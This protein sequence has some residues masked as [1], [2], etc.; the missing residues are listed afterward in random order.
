MRIPFHVLGKRFQHYLGPAAKWLDAVVERT[1]WGIRGKL[2]SIFIVIKV[3][4][5]VL[6]AWFAWTQSDQLGKLLALDATQLSKT[7][8]QS[9]GDVGQLAT[10]DSM[11]ALNVRMREELERM[12]TDAALRIAGF[13]HERDNDIRHAASLE[14]DEKLYRAFLANHNG[15][16]TTQGRWELAPDGKTWQPAGKKSGAAEMVTSSI[17]ENAREF[18]YRAP[19]SPASRQSRPLFLEMTFVDLEGR[20]KVKISNSPRLPSELSDISRRENTYTKAET[21]F[22]DLKRLKPGDIY[23]SEVI[24]PYVGS[25]IIGHY[26]PEAA[27]KAGIPFEPEKAAYAGKE[28]PVGR[29]FQG[30]VR[31]AA[32]VVKDGRITGYVTLALD[33]DHLMEFTSTLIP[34]SERYTDIPDAAAGNYAFIWDHRG[35]NIA[36]PRHHFI[37]GYRPDTGKPEVPWLETSIEEAWRK[38]G[39]P[40]SEFIADVPTF[41]QQS[42]KKKLSPTLK[43]E[44]R[45][46]LD[47]RYLNAAPQCTGWFDLTRLGG[48][49]SFLISWSGLWKITTAAAIPYHT[50]QYAK[51]PR[52]FGIVTIGANIDEF[53]QPANETKQRIDQMVAKT[54]QELA[55]QEAATQATIR[56][57]LASTAWS[58]SLSTILMSIL[59]IVIAV[60]MASYLT[61]RIKSL[62][63]GISRFRQGEHSFRF[64][65]SNKDEMGALAT[66]FDAMADTIGNTL[67]QLREEIRQHQATADE[68][69]AMQLHLEQL[70]EQRTAELSTANMRLQ[71]EIVER[72][73]AEERARHLALHDPLT[74]LANRRQ[75]QDRLQLSMA[76][77]NRSHKG[78][79]LLYLDLDRFKQVNDSFGHETGD[80]LLKHVANQLRACVRETD[81]VARLGGDEFVALL[82][83]V[84]TPG[85]C[86]R[87]ANTILASLT[88]PVALLGHKL[89]PGTSIG[90]TFF[91]DDHD[92]PEQLLRQADMAMYQAKQSGGNAYRFFAED[93]HER[94]HQR[95]QME[96]DLRAALIAK[97]LVL[98]YQTRHE[99]D[100]PKPIGIEALI[101]W[102]HPQQ[103]LLLPET[104][105]SLA[106]SADQ[107][108]TIDAWALEEACRQAGVWNE[109]GLD[110]GRIAINATFANIADPDFPQRCLETL[111]RHKLSPNQVDIEITESSLIERIGNI[112][113]NLATLRDHGVRITLDDFGVQ[114]SSLH[115]LVDYPIDI[116]KIN[117]YFISRIDEDKSRA[118]IEAT[119]LLA[120]SLGVEV[121]AEGIET[122]AQEE[123]LRQH[124]CRI[125]QGMLY[126][127]PVPA[128]EITNRL[129]KLAGR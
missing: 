65:S 96:N 84:E 128:A 29:R 17:E 72:R 112:A 82:T 38:S 10:A 30:L 26:T 126:A 2:I 87:V 68:L 99:L 46:G 34:N 79:A 124:G 74:G 4:P 71:E 80:A 42:L 5:L 33:H 25:R 88:K 61:N 106:E 93:M 21:Y 13:L 115:H 64:G 110:F 77:V 45:V 55:R 43:Q 102:N 3:V 51:S 101:R 81:V 97:Q 49:G 54:D 14:P 94:V 32:P 111:Q 70:V 22:A 105:L 95:E 18:H 116:L 69:R 119:L 123:Y 52:G 89:Q 44:G 12:T 78:Q 127:A 121:V 100:Q 91:D 39:K 85:N 48:S 83:D 56:G 19:D 113:T 53:Y 114:H 41:D 67:S 73:N 118:I 24:G 50:G 57:N 35:R 63:G 107:L 108:Y 92:D 103:G 40:F 27:T 66:S 59:V 9:V 76:Q 109:A 86:V 90:I 37:V 1:G 125:M 98:Y 16:L 28:N 120:S 31:W 11:K 117:R 104:F 23:V 7:A 75:F 122:P 36:H 129:E 58:L 60:W 6:L 20:E 15:I 62:I 8:N 47:C